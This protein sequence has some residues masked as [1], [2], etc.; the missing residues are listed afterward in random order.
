MRKFFRE[1]FRFIGAL[2][3]LVRG[4]MI[5]SMLA[6]GALTV[7]LIYTTA[8]VTINQYNE[9]LAWDNT[10]YEV[11][12]SEIEPALVANIRNTDIV[13]AAAAWEELE[14]YLDNFDGQ[15]MSDRE[16]AENLLTE[17]VKWQEVYNLKSNAIT[18]LSL[19]LDLEDAIKDA[20]VTMDTTELSTL[21]QTLYTL[22]L[23]E[24]TRAGQQYMERL[25]GV[26]SD[27]TEA[28]KLMTDTVMSVGTVEDGIWTIPYTYTRTDMTQVLEQIQTM[29]KFT[30]LSDSVNVLSDIADV[31][32][33][34]KN[35]REYFEYQTFKESTGGLKR[36]SYVPV[37][38]IYTYGQALAFGCDVQLQEQEGYVVSMESSIAGLYYNGDRLSNDDYVKRGTKLMAV[39]N[40]IYEPIEPIISESEP[41]V[42]PE[43]VTEQ[44]VYEEPQEVY[45]EPQEEW[46]DENYE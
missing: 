4:I 2:L 28:E 34:N 17:A 29:Q 33:Y 21:A 41:E 5:L 27:F 32:N 31:L 24:E 23:E 42:I 6:V 38:S 36:S 13:E 1:T 16:I 46:S 11:P 10:S 14:K 26:A 45:E 30:A 8:Q 44:P 40:E 43:I 22:E 15:E 20:Y 18:R 39:I 3:A 7:Y 25:R 9:T 12:L 19:Y 37:S 35:A